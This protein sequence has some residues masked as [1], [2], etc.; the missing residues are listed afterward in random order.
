MHAYL[1]TTLYHHA[2]YLWPHQSFKRPS[3]FLDQSSVLNY[4]Y[5]YLYHTVIVYNIQTPVV[6]WLLLA[7]EK[8]F[9]AHL[10]PIDFWMSISL[11]AVTLFIL[12]VEVIFNRMIISINMVLL[13]FGTVLLYM[14]LVFIIF[15]VEHWWVYSFLDWSV[16]PSAIIWYLAISVF[17]V[18]CFFLQ[19]GL[20]K[21]RDRIAMRCVKKY[22]SRQLATTTDNDE[23]K[24][25]PSEITQTSNFEP[26]ASTIGA[27]SRI[28][29]NE[30]STADM[31]NHSSIYY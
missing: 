22:R 10:S 15:A 27:S 7:K 19:V 6:F 16:G 31:S 20:H 9:E 14:C 12:M 2:K 21:A 26:L 24:E 1:M 28:T 11:H 18:L 13:V 8:L 25:V 5:V 30:T 29:F 23:K 4:A 3:S 17:I